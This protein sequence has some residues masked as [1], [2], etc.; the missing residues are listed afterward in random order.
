MSDALTII[1]TK[2]LTEAET[3]ELEELFEGQLEENMEG[4]KPQIPV[5]T[6]SSDAFFVMPPDKEHDEEWTQK[7]ISAF[8]LKKFAVRSY[9]AQS[10]SDDENAMPDCYSTD[11]ITPNKQI[12][13]PRSASCENCAMNQWK[14]A[15]DKSGQPMRGKACREKRKLFIRFNDLPLPYILHIPLTSLRAFD[16]YVTNLTA[17]GIPLIAVQTKLTA[18]PTSKGEMKWS[19]VE[20]ERDGRVKDKEHLKEL[21]SMQSQIEVEPKDAGKKEADDGVPF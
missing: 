14:S 1:D 18:K 3:K 13:E 19:L 16:A 2:D 6:L 8:I 4:I 20:F 5:A 9:Y 11:S 7:S 21:I 12:D 15:R 17:A 10:K